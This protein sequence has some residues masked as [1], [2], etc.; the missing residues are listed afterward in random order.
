M[1]QEAQ[2][3]EHSSMVATNLKAS[4]GDLERKNKEE[5]QK[6]KWNVRSKVKT[7]LEARLK[8]DLE[9]ELVAELEAELV[10]DLE[11]EQKLFD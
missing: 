1:K 6:M 3:Q 2:S 11:E 9:E 7:K 5:I 4:E 8:N 10:K